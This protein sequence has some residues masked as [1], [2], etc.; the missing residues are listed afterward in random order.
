MRTL[1]R[2]T[3]S[4]HYNSLLHFSNQLSLITLA[5]ILS[6]IHSEQ[7]TSH[8][9][10]LKKI[11]KTKLFYQFWHTLFKCA[12]AAL[13]DF[14]LCPS[15]PVK[16]IFHLGPQS[17]PLPQLF[18]F[19]FLWSIDYPIPLSSSFPTNCILLFFIYI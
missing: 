17:H 8:H 13:A 3:H 19:Q 16:A 10:S 12:S 6:H 1:R 5:F 2:H 9:L 14:N 11:H 18:N 7:L 15:L 4:V